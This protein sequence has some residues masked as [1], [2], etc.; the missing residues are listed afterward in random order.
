M[1]DTY[2]LWRRA[3]RFLV[4][5]LVVVADAYRLLVRYLLV[6]ADVAPTLMYK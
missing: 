2:W 6:V 1:Y 3:Y 5:R 4:Q